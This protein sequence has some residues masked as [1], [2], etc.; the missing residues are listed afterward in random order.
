MGIVN[1]IG[2]STGLC[3]IFYYNIDLKLGDVRHLIFSDHDILLEY[4]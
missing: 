4:S 3:F 1:I 2:D